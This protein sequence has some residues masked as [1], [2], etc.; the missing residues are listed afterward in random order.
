MPIDPE[1]SATFDRT[2]NLAMRHAAEMVGFMLSQ[3]DID[4]MS[5]R[6]ALLLLQDQFSKMNQVQKEPQKEP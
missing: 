1:V 4:K 2:Y 6:S 3:P 5:T